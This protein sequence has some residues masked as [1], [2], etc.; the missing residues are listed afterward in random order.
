MVIILLGVMTT[1][2]LCLLWHKGLSVR[3][4]MDDES[5]SFSFF[6]QILEMRKAPFLV[7]VFGK[8]SGQLEKNIS[9]RD[10][11]MKVWCG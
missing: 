5:H 4:A 8:K 1:T 7:F 10:I 3:A 6:I 11:F 9:G 2:G